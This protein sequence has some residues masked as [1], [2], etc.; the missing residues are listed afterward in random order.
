MMI[1]EYDDGNILV[2]IGFESRP[3]SLDDVQLLSALEEIEYIND[4]GIE[5]SRLVD[6]EG[7]S[8]DAESLRVAREAYEEAIA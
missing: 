2:E 5:A 6:A 7:Y 4:Q 3:E 1:A 8:L